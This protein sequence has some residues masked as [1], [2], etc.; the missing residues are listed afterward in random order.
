ML[1]QQTGSLLRRFVQENTTTDK[2]S[3]GLEGEWSWTPERQTS[4]EAL[5]SVSPSAEYNED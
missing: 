2:Q 4:S 3:L 5:V 1:E